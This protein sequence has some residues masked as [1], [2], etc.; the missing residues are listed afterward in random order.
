V[1]K[2]KVAR[3]AELIWLTGSSEEMRAGEE[4]KISKERN[5]NRLSTL[6]PSWI[7]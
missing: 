2:E 3:L 7:W 5:P 6:I 4:T 1:S